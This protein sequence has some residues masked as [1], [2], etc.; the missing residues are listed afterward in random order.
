MANP[1]DKAAV[2]T[3]IVNGEIK[4]K[5]AKRALVQ[6]HPKVKAEKPKATKATQPTTH[7]K[8]DFTSEQL[9]EAVK[10]VGHA[11]SS[12]E[13]SDK[14]KIADPDQGRAYIR[15]RMRALMEDGKVIGIEPEAKSRCT[16]LYSIVEA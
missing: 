8:L 15:R 9:I 13:I 4:V 14:L 10:A 6:A 16:F 2:V 7:E 11:A 1:T 3:K 12:R 5:S